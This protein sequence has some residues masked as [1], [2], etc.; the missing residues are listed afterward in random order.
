[1]QAH[2]SQATWQLRHVSIFVMQLTN[3][4]PVQTLGDFENHP[5][6]A[7]ALPQ[8]HVAAVASHTR[9]DWTIMTFRTDQQLPEWHTM[10]W[11]PRSPVVQLV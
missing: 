2:N 1:M 3:T 7:L 8:Y 11:A 10:W 5:S 4:T 9:S 6:F